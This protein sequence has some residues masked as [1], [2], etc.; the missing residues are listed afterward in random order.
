[1]DTALLGPRLCMKWMA[2]SIQGWREWSEVAISV[3]GRPHDFMVSSRKHQESKQ[4]L[5][6]LGAQPQH[7]LSNFYH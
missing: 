3:E 5:G 1:M 4:V 6:S 2:H 7:S